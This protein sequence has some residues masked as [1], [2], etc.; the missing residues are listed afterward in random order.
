MPRLQ[1]D[2]MPYSHQEGMREVDHT[3]REAFGESRQALLAGL[4][5]PER[6]LTHTCIHK[7]GA[8]GP[9]QLA[10][11]WMEGDGWGRLKSYQGTSKKGGILFIIGLFQI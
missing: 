9:S 3:D 5:Y 11:V 6:H 1:F 2:L 8:L 7:E 4:K 10:Q